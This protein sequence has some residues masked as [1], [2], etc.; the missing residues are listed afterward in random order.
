[1]EEAL[2]VAICEDSQPDQSR[3][4]QL[5]RESR[6]AA[7]CTLFSNGEDLCKHYTP[8]KY[9]LLMMDIYMEGMTGVEAISRIREVDREVPVAFV[10][11][12]TEFA[13]EGYRLSA[14][15][16]LEKPVQREEVEESL[17]LARRMRAAV[18]SFTYRRQ[19]TE[20]RVRMR[21]LLYLEQRGHALLLHL[22]GDR[23]ERLYDKLS[24]HLAQLEQR[25]FFSPHKSYCVNL[26]A[27]R[28]LEPELR[29]FVMQ[30][31]ENV[32]I[33]RE[34]MGQAKKV[35]LDHLCRKTRG[36]GA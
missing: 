16:Y 33:R 10:T 14:L 8:Q 15:K 28:Q 36:C 30:N 26:D 18:P 4:L 25:G 11:S 1:M 35:L 13:L 27:V 22:A 21:D 6:I 19:G 34:S 32:P 31:G 24:A 2:Q 20:Y 9:D 29:C 17:E 23:E 12:S 7:E 3:L 5:I